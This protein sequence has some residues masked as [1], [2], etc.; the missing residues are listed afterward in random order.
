MLFEYSGIFRG[1]YPSDWSVLLV[2]NFDLDKTR[3][4]FEIYIRE[5]WIGA[6]R[7]ARKVIIP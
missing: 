5:S 7:S 3:H 2:G 4:L 1:C 6:I